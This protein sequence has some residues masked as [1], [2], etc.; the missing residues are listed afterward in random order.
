MVMSSGPAAAF[1]ARRCP[2]RGRRVATFLA[3]CS[4]VFAVVAPETAEASA[5]KA[6]PRCP[7]SARKVVCVD[8]NHQTLWVQQGGKII[9]PRVRIRTGKPGRRTPDGLFHIWL[10]NRHQYSYLF[11]EPMPFS[12]FFHGNFALHGTYGDVRKGGSNGCVNLTL[13]DA[14]KLFPML[15]RGDAVYIWGHKPR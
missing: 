15:G 8:Q 6:V 13:A 7:Q 1:P 4:L 12:L 3:A 14:A 5:T 10:R 9:F 11:H 2:A